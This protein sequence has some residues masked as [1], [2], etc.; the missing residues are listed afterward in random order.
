MN[1]YK[2]LDPTGRN[3]ERGGGVS[4]NLFDRYVHKRIGLSNALETT[5]HGHGNIF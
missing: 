5:F 3:P 2:G 4:G 1:S